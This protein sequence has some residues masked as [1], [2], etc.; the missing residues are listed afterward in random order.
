MSSTTDAKK[1]T[2]ADFATFLNWLHL[3]MDS[4]TWHGKFQKEFEDFWRFFFTESEHDLSFYVERFEYAL[5]LVKEGPIASWFLWLKEKFT[6]FAYIHKGH[7][8][9][10]LRVLHGW[11]IGKTATLMRNYF[12]ELCPFMEEELTHYFQMSDLSDQNIYE[13]F[14]EFAQKTAMTP[15]LIEEFKN[16]AGRPDDVLPSLEVTLYPEWK[17]IYRE[18]KKETLHSITQNVARERRKSYVRGQ[19]KFLRDLVLL[20]VVGLLAIYLV[21]WGNAW[22]KEYLQN[23][24]SIYG[25]EMPWLDR[26]LVFKPPRDDLEKITEELNPE[27]I[28]EQL[29]EASISWLISE[30]EERFETESEVML[31]TGQFLPRDFSSIDREYSEF[32]ERDGGGYRDTRF[33]NL[34]VYRV[35]MT[36]VNTYASRERLNRLLPIYQALQVDNVRPGQFVPGGVYYNLYIPDE[37]LREFLEDVSSVDDA[38][39]YESRARGRVRAPAGHSKVFIWMKDL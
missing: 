27:I 3:D 17:L 28:E 18:L 11:K 34:T 7:T 6:L 21:Q 26:T 15:S 24:I 33:G 31:A 14:S 16:F 23:K 36:S 12:L 8:V 2:P 35:M 19:F 39:I 1:F 30:L 13:T 9:Y 25:P 37:K 10:D 32:E 22:Y 20:V 29:G 4:V 38:V 5:F